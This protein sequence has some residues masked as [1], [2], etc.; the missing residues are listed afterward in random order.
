MIF[1]VVVTTIFWC[2]DLKLIFFH[3]YLIRNKL[4][5]YGYIMMQR[6][7]TKSD[8]IKEKKLSRFKNRK[9]AP[10]YIDTKNKS[11]Y[12]LDNIHNFCRRS[13]D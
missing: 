9:V 8:L 10:S 7:K 6:E 13:H 3:I 1:F 2:L 4:T 12:C 11:N 5:T